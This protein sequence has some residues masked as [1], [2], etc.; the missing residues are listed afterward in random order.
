[1]GGAD[2]A[3]LFPYPVGKD[4]NTSFPVRKALIASIYFSSILNLS[5][6]LTVSIGPYL[7]NHLYLLLSEITRY[8]I[9][10]LNH[11]LNTDFPDPFHFVRVGGAGYATL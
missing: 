2:Y 5:L 8:L 1:M 3:R 11:C 6:P 9:E 4:P 10:A 7:S